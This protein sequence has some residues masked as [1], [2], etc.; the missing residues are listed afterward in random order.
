MASL[1][2]DPRARTPGPWSRRT[3]RIDA[4]LAE[5]NCELPNPGLANCRFWSKPVLAR[6]A[7]QEPNSTLRRLTAAE[8]SRRPAMSGLAWLADGAGLHGHF[9]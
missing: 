7:S 4:T 3:L 9:S 1:Q 6:K 2:A 5:D 8:T